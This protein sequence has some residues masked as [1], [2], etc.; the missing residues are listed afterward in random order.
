MMQMQQ[1]MMVGFGEMMRSMVESMRQ[2][3]QNQ[4][5]PLEILTL[6]KTLFDKPT[7]DNPMEW[8]KQGMEL[9][10]RTVDK[11]TS[12]VDVVKDLVSTAGPILK[13]ALEN[14]PRSPNPVPVPIQRPM[15]T[16]ADLQRFAQIEPA[17]PIAPPPRIEQI[18]SASATNTAPED[19]KTRLFN[20]LH[21][22]IS[23]N[24]PPHVAVAIIQENITDDQAFEIM[25]HFNNPA[26]MGDLLGYDQRFIGHE[27]WLGRAAAEFMSYFTDEDP[28][29][30]PVDNSTES[31]QTGT[32]I[33]KPDAVIT[34]NGSTEGAT[35]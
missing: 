4:R 31:P 32:E 2:P 19:N 15:G 29:A 1:Q 13:S 10:G 23:N 6:A 11:E 3:Q 18:Q 9:A 8:L 14:R 30:P 12:A 27:E 17:G 28:N 5:D 26:W 20:A 7:L 24:A 21:E 35:H 16:P 33:A 25:E 34:E 22:F